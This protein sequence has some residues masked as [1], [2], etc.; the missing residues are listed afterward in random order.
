M[1]FNLVTCK[2][3]TLPAF[4]LLNHG[5]GRLTGAKTQFFLSKDLCALVQEGVAGMI[6]VI[7]IT[8]KVGSRGTLVGI[9]QLPNE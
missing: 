8:L 5:D 3:A 4:V 6:R 7:V 9:K 1:I 2:Q